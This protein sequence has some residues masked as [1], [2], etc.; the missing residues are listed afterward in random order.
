MEG[1]TE[2]KFGAEIEGRTIKKLPHLRIHPII[3]HLMQTL[4]YMPGP[5]SR[6]GWVGE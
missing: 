2:R 5:G 3:S 6:S 1:V 4:L